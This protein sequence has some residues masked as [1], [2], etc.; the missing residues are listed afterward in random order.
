VADAV[1]AR[2]VAAEDHGASSTVQQPI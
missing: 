1:L 2:L